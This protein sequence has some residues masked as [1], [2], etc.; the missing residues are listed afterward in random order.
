MHQKSPNVLIVA[1]DTL[2]GEVIEHRVRLM[3]WEAMCFSR[4]EELDLL[5]AAGLPQLFIIDL[6]DSGAMGLNLVERLTT[7]ERTSRIPVLCISADGDLNLAELAFRTGAK[8]FLLVPFD[9]LLLQQKVEKWLST[10]TATSN[11]V[12]AKRE[13]SE[14]ATS[15]I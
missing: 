1:L 14:L 2:V 7:D 3:G 8:D 15:S 4:N 13:A 11:P 5:L 12:Q 6:D 10:G 9:I